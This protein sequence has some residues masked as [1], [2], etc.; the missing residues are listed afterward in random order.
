MLM[1]PINVRCLRGIQNLTPGGGQYLFDRQNYRVI[2][3]ILAIS[4][5]IILAFERQEQETQVSLIKQAQTETELK[6]LQQQ[7]NPHFLFNTLNNL[8]ALVLKK[9]RTSA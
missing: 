4:T 6:F 5:P 3:S 8:Y 1:L 7:V 9:I 2:F